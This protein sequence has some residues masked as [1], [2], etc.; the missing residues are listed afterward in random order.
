MMASAILNTFTTCEIKDVVIQKNKATISLLLYSNRPSVE[1][2]FLKFYLLDLKTNNIIEIN[3]FNYWLDSF[4]GATNNI[5][6]KN[7]S[8]NFYKRLS[9]VIDIS[10]NQ[11][12]DFD[13]DRWYREIRIVAK[14]FSLNELEN[15]YEVENINGSWFSEPI[16]LISEKI[17]IPIIKNLV[18]KSYSSDTEANEDGNYESLNVFLHYDYQQENDFSYINSNIKY[19]VSL[20]NALSLA[21]IQSLVVSENGTTDLDSKIGILELEF[22]GLKI[23]SPIIV[24]IDIVNP[25]E[26][27]LKTISRI[28]RPF[29]PHT[30]TYIKH[31]GIVK[32]ILNIYVSDIN[33]PLEGNG[34]LNIYKNTTGLKVKS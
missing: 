17:N 16:T 31:K 2:K 15:G 29:T 13:I 18:I 9:F 26:V 1:V 8:I 32:E 7:V 33:E 6:N 10:N 5:S 30:R 3:D 12:A 23:N 21:P 27:V 19:K 34:E 22:S 20:T 28:Y 4:A 25:L 14:V 11:S 24:T